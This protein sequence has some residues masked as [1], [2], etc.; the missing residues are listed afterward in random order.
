MSLV[1]FYNDLKK[2]KTISNSEAMEYYNVPSGKIDNIR[3]H[4]SGRYFG[5]IE[6]NRYLFILSV[7]DRLIGIGATKNTATRAQYTFIEKGIFD[8]ED[9]IEFLNAINNAKHIHQIAPRNYGRTAHAY[10]CKLYNIPL[11][12]TVVGKQKKDVLKEKIANLT[13]NIRDENRKLKDLFTEL[14]KVKEELLEVERNE[15]KAS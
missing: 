13:N 3:Q 14:I 5:A 11:S 6:D 4:V 1:S 7:Y 9:A 10:L 15:S 12:Y 8:N 2:G